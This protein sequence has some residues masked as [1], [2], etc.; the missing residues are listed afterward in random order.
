MDSVPQS[1]VLSS[2]GD[3]GL[4]DGSWPHQPYHGVRV[5]K[6]L[7]TT[8]DWRSVD[9]ILADQ[10][11]RLPA[12]RMAKDNKLV[13]VQSI[14]R[15]DTATSQGIRGLADPVGILAELGRGA[16]LVLQGLHRFWPPLRGVTRRLAAEVGHAVFANA[17]LTPRCAQ[18][19]GP[20]HDP[21]HAWL[22]QTEG[23]K[24]WRLWAPDRDPATDQPDQA[25]LL[26]EGDVLWIPR[27]WWH[28]GTSG[29]EPSLH[30][31]FTVWATTLADVLR[32]LVADLSQRTEL[33]RELPPNALREQPS[34]TASIADAA[35]EIA[36]L[37]AGTTPA[38]L[39]DHVIDARLD[40][41]DPLPARPVAAILAGD[42]DPRYHTHP[43][44]VLYSAAEG[45]FT[46]LRT[47]DAVVLVPTDLLP[48]CQ[49]LLN[50]PGT[51]GIDELDGPFTGRGREVLDQLIDARLVCAAACQDATWHSRVTPEE[52]R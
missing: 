47:T 18:G 4:F 33:A 7:R 14:T 45:S 49:E 2:F 40:R 6:D 42:H 20:H 36:R 23:A 35:A 3:P 38:T 8:L 11:I 52:T 13:P 21:Y 22:V 46:R 28:S 50:R 34:G 43:D 19:F 32:V 24:A 30:L 27:G 41:F 51:F 10:G 39:T 15:P 48:A 1:R 5:A 44:G 9:A 12:F 25:I 29:D 16:T 31:T 26:T 37:I 17:Y